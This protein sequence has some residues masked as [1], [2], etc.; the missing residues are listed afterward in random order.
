MLYWGRVWAVALDALTLP[1]AETHSERNEEG[2]TGEGV[3]GSPSP[4]AEGTAAT[5]DQRERQFAGV[6]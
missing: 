3:G 4:E 6:M 2:S 5:P 1:G